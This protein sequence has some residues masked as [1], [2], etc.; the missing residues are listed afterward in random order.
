MQDFISIIVPVYNAGQYIIPCLESLLSQTYQNIEIIL[1]DDGSTD[2]SLHICQEYAAQNPCVRVLHQENGG[3]S[4]ARNAGLAYAQGE[5]VAFID[6]DDYVKPDYLAVLLEALKQHDADMVCCNFIEILNGETVHINTEKVVRERLVT[7]KKELLTDFLS[8]QEAYGTCVWSKL[9]RRELAAKE[10][11]KKI[12]FGEDAEYMMRLFCRAPRVYLT[13]YPGYV[14]IRN[15]NSATMQHNEKSVT[16]CKNE[17]QMT[18]LF[19]ENL[20]ADCAEILPLYQNRYA[21]ALHALASATVLAKDTALY[22]QYRGDLLKR[23][24]KIF[25]S[26][27]PLTPKT[28]LYLHLY[29]RTPWLYK[30]LLQLKQTL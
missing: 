28:K 15:E 11:F 27:V 5:F 29:A 13:L 18:E 21:T 16:R 12:K 9:I 1:V 26:K 10:A 2:D 20:P 3:V 24:H 8:R 7:D 17:L 25:E 23:I 22:R 4:A 6:A 19:I 30:F 14:Y